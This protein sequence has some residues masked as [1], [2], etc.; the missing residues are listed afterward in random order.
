VLAEQAQQAAFRELV[1]LQ[2]RLYRI[3]APLMV[4]N[5][6]LCPNRAYLLGFTARTVFDS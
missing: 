5:L 4:S 1:M 2:D 6:A 3:A